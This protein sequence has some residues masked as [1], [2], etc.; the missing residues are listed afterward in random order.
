[1]IDD[2]FRDALRW[3]RY[4]I[5]GI[6]IVVFAFLFLVV[7]QLTLLR[8]DVVDIRVAMTLMSGRIDMIDVH[9]GRALLEH[10]Q[11]AHDRAK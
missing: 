6:G 4:L 8:R 10:E 3:D 7:W 1:M 9:G 2:E 11:S 5:G